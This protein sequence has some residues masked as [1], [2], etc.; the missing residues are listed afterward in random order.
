[1]PTFGSN[2]GS[3]N[4]FM[5]TLL[6][7]QNQ[8]ATL[9]AAPATGTVSQ[10]SVYMAGQGGPVSMQ[11]CVWDAAGNLIGVSG[12]GAV[13][14]GSDTSGGQFLVTVNV[15]CQIV[16]G[17]NYYIGFW[18]DPS[19]GAVWSFLGGSGTFYTSTTP[20]S[21][22]AGFLSGLTSNTGQIQAFATYGT[23]P[24]PPP[25]RTFVRRTGAW[26]NAPVKIRRS[27][28]WATPQVFVRRNG[29]WVK[30]Q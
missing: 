15:N 21:S 13:G 10:V 26:S 25:V 19:A 30:V 14:A 18:R 5:F 20:G 4:N 12:M 27:G 11:G 1:M 16:S 22:S 17:L 8:V 23:A 28:A 24:A 3:F 2:P 29:T 7:N 6:N 9:A